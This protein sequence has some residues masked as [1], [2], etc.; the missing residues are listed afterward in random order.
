M[1]KQLSARSA[2]AAL[3][4]LAIIAAPGAAFSADMDPVYVEEPVTTPVEFGS[5]WYL[6]G[7]VGY[8]SHGPFDT[9]GTRSDDLDLTPVNASGAIGYT[10]SD[11]LRGEV[12]I[13][14]LGSYSFDDSHDSRCP[15]TSTFTPAG[16]GADVIGP[17][18]IDCEG[19][20]SGQNEMW[21]GLVNGYIDL[22]NYGGFKP[23][24]GGGLGLVFNNYSGTRGERN[25]TDSTTTDASGTTV[26][27]CDDATTP[28]DS[29]DGNSIGFL[30]ALA[31]GF[32]YQISESTTFDLG[33]RYL[34][35]PN[36]TQLV[37]LPDGVDEE[38]GM[39][40][41]QFRVGLRYAIW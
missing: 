40:V 16:G 41:H 26:L 23:Y 25:C 4:A 36:S 6:R 2:H 12:E 15:G 29:V 34:S 13:G 31:A 11:Y 1:A 27:T 32:G 39:S 7:D 17:A 19:G 33:Y 35:S 21:N 9:S 38:E 3:M 20:D 22:G 5:G 14:Y 18:S 8:S 24:V 28:S 30:W 10:F 37:N